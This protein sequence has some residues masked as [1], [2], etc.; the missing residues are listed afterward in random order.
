MPNEFDRFA[1]EAKTLTDDQFK[2]RFSSLTS[3]NDSEVSSIINDT[4]ISKKNLAETIRLVKDATVQ[5]E[6]NAEAIMNI[7]K[8]ID[9][10]IAIAGKVL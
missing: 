4:G 8:G 2:N 6:H 1:D 9:A 3:L 7:S 5:N 10:V